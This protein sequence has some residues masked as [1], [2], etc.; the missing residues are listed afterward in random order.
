MNKVVEA[1]LRVIAE[2]K[3]G[4][5]FS[6]I[7]GKMNLV[8]RQALALN[9]RT[10]SFGRYLD[11]V[12]ARAG[13]FA[14][15]AGAMGTAAGYAAGEV[16][17]LSAR[18]LGPAAIG[19]GLA[20][21]TREAANF[22]ESLFGIQKKSGATAEEME[23]IKDQIL[24]VTR[25]MPVA[26][27]EVAAAFERGAAAG[28]PLDE[29]AS[30]A[31]LTAKVADAW[32]MAAEDVGNVFA[33]FEKGL[34]VP[35]RDI[36]K[37]A[38]LINDLAD[39]GISDEKDIADFMDRAGA[40]LKNFGLSAEEIAAYGAALLNLKMPSEVAAR[41]MDTVTGKLLAPENLSPKSR[42]ALTKIVGDM[43]EFQKLSGNARLMFFLEKL[44]GLSGQQRASYLGA[45]LG[46]GFDDEIMR[47]V[48]GLE[49]LRRNLDMVRKHNERPSDSIA[50][51]SEKKLNLFNSQ[52]Q[53]LVNNIKNAQTS[54]GENLMQPVAEVLK[55]VN[56]TVDRNALIRSGERKLDKLMGDGASS[57]TRS[58]LMGDFAKLNPKNIAAQNRWLVDQAFADY[59]AGKIKHP[60]A[61]LTAM[62]RD[63][64][65]A[66]YL[67]SNR[68]QMEAAYS[69]Y[70][71]GGRGGTPIPLP[72]PGTESRNSSLAE[73]YALYRP[74]RGPDRFQERS[75]DL[76]RILD[77]LEALEKGGSGRPWLD[78]EKVGSEVGEAAVQRISADAATIGGEMGDALATVAKP[79]LEAIGPVIAQHIRAAIAGSSFQVNVGGG[80]RSV[81]A[82]TGRSMP[83]SAGL[84]VTAGR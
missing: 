62:Q 72:R 74:G 3:T 27:E 66:D 75:A 18:F 61:A 77:N 70:R 24:A 42:T 26:R 45:M 23:K 82:D 52:L 14:S 64:D 60:R 36:E 51:V 21:A 29:L 54:L 16:G 22:E 43:N 56:D 40:S 35:L 19:V 7:A 47:A 48:G 67:S 84:P 80:G 17:L 9:R 11:A 83:T 30:F 44:E 49:E 55:E 78:Q 58:I 6:T 81:N 53:R 13:V 41:A 59:E 57:D 28:I 15:R 76:V 46:D 34:G 38:S 68:S 50:G 4:R 10:G 20:S 8:E 31:T 12:N 63:R 25:Q 65:R 37:L 5:A 71:I 33:G 79:I 2:D 69:A 39:S 73:Q 32:D 1:R